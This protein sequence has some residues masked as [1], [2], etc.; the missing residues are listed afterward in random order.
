MNVFRA[1]VKSSSVVRMVGLACLVALVGGVDAADHRHHAGDAQL[2]NRINKN[3][4]H[5]LHKVGHHTAH[6]HVQGGKVKH[7][8]IDHK[9]K[10]GVAVKKFKTRKNVAQADS[11][12]GY[13]FVS[14]EAEAMQF[15]VLVGW[16]FT[17]GFR[18]YFF[19][20]PVNQVQGG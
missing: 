1:I 6:A 2:G 3:G 15:T 9:T 11:A 7:I 12:D 14:A 10:G 20:F 13:H 18:W 16:G 5:A 19:W 4:K 8:S 17:D